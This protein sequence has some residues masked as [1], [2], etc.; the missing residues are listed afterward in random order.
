MEY[1][2]NAITY[3]DEVKANSVQGTVYIQFI[4]DKT[5]SIRNPNVLRGVHE[6]L[7]AEAINAVENMPDWEA[8][9][10]NKEPVNVQF[11]MPIRF[12]IS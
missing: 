10:H 3:P 1:L 4:I 6:A 5:G 2:Q 9:Q 8:A 11:V 7:D 12:T